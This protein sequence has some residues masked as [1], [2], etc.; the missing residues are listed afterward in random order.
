MGE[1]EGEMRIG[2][3]NKGEG[4]EGPCLR[5]EYWGLV[6]NGIPATTGEADLTEG[7]RKAVEDQKLKDLKAKNYLFQAVDRS[8]LE[9]ILNKDTS[10]NIWDSLKQKYQ[11]TTRVNRAQLQALRK[12]FE[13]LHMKAG[14]SVNEY[15]ARTLTIANKMR[16]HGEKLGDVLVIEK[17]LRS[18][19]S[20]FDYVVCS[21]E[22][23]HDLDSMSIDKLQSSLL[24][25]E[26][27]MNDHVTKEQALKVTYDESSGGRGHRRG[28]FRGRD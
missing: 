3:K 5:R 17:V 2:K 23:S 10:K 6:E 19:T 4:D 28:S 1:E 7:Q 20:K 12:E 25:H 21:I 22:E 26:Q 11:G 14:E 16:L 13:I 24:M 9:T 18:M 15:F 27:H 8:I